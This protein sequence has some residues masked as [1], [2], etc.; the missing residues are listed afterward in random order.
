[1]GKI[2]LNVARM[3]NGLGMKVYGLDPYASPVIAEQNNVKLFPTLET[4]LPLCD[5]ITL[6]T[7]LTASTKGLISAPE[8]KLM[9]RGARILNVAR[10]GMIDEKD[11]LEALEQGHIAGAGIDVYVIEPP[12]N[13]SISSTLIQ[14]PNVIAT[15]HLGA[16][17]KE[18]QE[19]VALDVCQQI[20]EILKGSLPKSA[21]NVPM[22]LEEE[23]KT[24]QPF[25]KLLEKMGNLYYQHYQ[26]VLK[27]NH[28]MTL[29]VVYEGNLAELKNTKPLY[30]ALVKGLLS[31]V[32]E[33]SIN[34]VN[35]ELIAKDRGLLINETRIR[36]PTTHTYSSLVTLKARPLKPNH[37]LT[38]LAL[39]NVEPIISGYSSEDEIFISRLDCF[40]TNFIPE[41][42]LIILHNF[43]RPGKIGKV[44]MELGKVDVNINFMMV[45]PRQG[46]ELEEREEDEALMI[47]G[48]D[49]EIEATTVEA[50]KG[51]EGI[52]D[53]SLVSL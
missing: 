16:S 27:G 31:N 29:E 4:L 14:H 32:T 3:A 35:A 43:N 22:I 33:A 21:V 50:L 28:S 8:L 52:L 10:G 20:L 47:L 44:G 13:D 53:V 42:N 12:P 30:A 7:P 45:A 37:S 11:L 49:R 40:L 51:I 26:K 5:F 41:G 19:N 46:S 25:V 48:V 2:G 34:I 18:A 9:K 6:H 23:F 17:T 24:L 36:S 39:T 1:M 38:K 15:P